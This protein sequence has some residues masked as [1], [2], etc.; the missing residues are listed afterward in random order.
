MKRMLHILSLLFVCATYG[1]AQE[2]LV[3]NA[4]IDGMPND[5][6]IYLYGFRGE[7]S[8]SVLVKNHSFHFDRKLKD[9]GDVYV[10][11]FGKGPE[12][13]A[14]LLTYLG[15]GQ[16]TI[17]GSWPAYDKSTITGPAFI[18]EFNDVDR[19]MNDSLLF[20]HGDQD[21]AAEMA[22][23]QQVGDRKR[24]KELE[25]AQYN[26]K[27][28]LMELGK[29][30]VMKHL[31][32][33]VSG[34]VINVTIS[35]QASAEETLALI[36]KLTPAAQKN[37]YVRVM[38]QQIGDIQAHVL[39]GMPLFAYADSLKAGKMLAPVFTS[40][41][42]LG[43]QVSLADFKGKYVLVDFWA[44]WCKPCR[45]ANP[46]LK[47]MYEKFKNK[48][49]TI[50]GIS[51]DTQKDAWMKAIHQDQLPWTQICDLA[52]GFTGKTAA[53]YQIGFIPTNYLVDPQGK[54]IGSF[55]KDAETL[56]KV[57]REH[58]VNNL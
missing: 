44:S 45:E 28:M 51:I 24:F 50:V 19:M 49:F 1:H 46:G 10:L 38:R 47:T 35:S 20:S 34:Y 43:R 58:G 37:A 26:Q 16:V 54:I 36:G 17:K 40:S 52:G 21:L 39:S 7:D 23:A 8:D 5:S 30:W 3:L 9:G 53:Q 2:N 56:E 15:P 12:P 57:L 6:T 11:K 18:E 41:D 25:A 42:T 29:K 4:T 22:E 48:N 31:N 13:S 14:A 55:I 33:G 27:L 32:S